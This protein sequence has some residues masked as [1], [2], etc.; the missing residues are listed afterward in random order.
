[1]LRT[2]STLYQAILTKL[3]AMRISA[4]VLLG[5]ITLM[6]LLLVPDLIA[7]RTALPTLQRLEWLVSLLLTLILVSITLEYTIAT[8]KMVSSAQEQVSE[9][10]KQLALAQEQLQ[11]E[12]EPNLVLAL[13]NNASVDDAAKKVETAD[14]TEV[15]LNNLGRYPVYINRVIFFIRLPET[16]DIFHY[17]F[18]GAPL[19]SGSSYKFGTVMFEQTVKPQLYFA[20]YEQYKDNPM[21]VEVHFHYSSTANKIHVHEFQIQVE[22]VENLGFHLQTGLVKKAVHE[23]VLFTH[24]A[25]NKLTL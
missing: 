19:L 23:G 15:W 17:L 3:A 11:L 4:A 16:T 1:M 10:Q 2:G 14:T 20:G 5:V 12:Y 13:V 21:K 9:A 25:P 22:H 7:G 24:L 8:R 18:P 6:L